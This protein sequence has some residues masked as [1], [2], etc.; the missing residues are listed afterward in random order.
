MMDIDTNWL[1]LQEERAKRL[2]RSRTPTPLKISCVTR[3]WADRG[4][5]TYEVEF[6]NGAIR[7]RSSPQKPFSG[8][9]PD[10]WQVYEELLADRQLAHADYKIDFA[11]CRNQE[12]TDARVNVLELQQ[13]HMVTCWVWLTEHWQTGQ[14]LTQTWELTRVNI[15][16]AV[17][18]YRPNQAPKSKL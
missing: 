1:M 16:R 8:K 18:Q 15:G 11:V 3:F 17:T 6:D 14:E 9:I 4:Q 5:D 7:F 13:K 10:A 12:I 2:E